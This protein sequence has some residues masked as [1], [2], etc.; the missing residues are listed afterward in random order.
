MHDRV[1]ILSGHTLFT[2]GLISRLKKYCDLFDF[3]VVDSRRPDV[4]DQIIALRPSVVIMDGSSPEI[5]ITTLLM[6]L[7]SSIPAL[8]VINLDSQSA[9]VRVIRWGS[10]T[11]SGVEEL[12]EE[13]KTYEELHVDT[14]SVGPG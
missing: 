1:L 6:D 2:E 14:P 13:I 5:Q 11:V 9:R 10:K 8:Q 3:Q 7:I 4:V 12:L